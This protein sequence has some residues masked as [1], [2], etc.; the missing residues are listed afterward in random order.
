MESSVDVSGVFGFTG[1]M[2]LL[3]SLVFPFGETIAE[4]DGSEACA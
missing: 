2:L 4:V 3:V 1:S